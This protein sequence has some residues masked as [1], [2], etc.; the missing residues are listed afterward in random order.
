[1][2]GKSKRNSQTLTLVNYFAKVKPETKDLMGN[3]VTVLKRSAPLTGQEAAIAS[4][5]QL[6]EDMLKV[7]EIAHPGIFEKARSLIIVHEWGVNSNC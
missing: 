1:M 4:Q 2:I 6:I 5:R 7:Y 3:V